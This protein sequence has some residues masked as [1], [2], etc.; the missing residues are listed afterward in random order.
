MNNDTPQ[1]RQGSLT[2]TL[3]LILIVIALTVAGV[4][5]I[6]NNKPEAKRHELAAYKVKVETIKLHL[7]QHR[8]RIDGTGEIKA[9]RSL[10]IK[11]EVSGLIIEEHPALEVGA[12]INEGDV[13]YKIDP[14]DT[15][16]TAQKIKAELETAKLRLKEEMGRQSLA[17]Q[18]WQNLQLEHANVLE[19]ELSL[20]EPHLAKAKADVEAAEASYA[21]AQLNIERCTIKAPFKCSIMNIYAH[22]GSKVSPQDRCCQLLD[23]SRLDF[24]LQ[25]RQEQLRWIHLDSPPKVI[26]ELDQ[27]QTL[28]GTIKHI[29]PELSQP[30]RMATVIVELPSPEALLQKEILVSRFLKAHFESEPIPNS[31]IIPRHAIHADQTVWI[32]SPTDTLVFQNIQWLPYGSDQALVLNGISDQQ[33]LIVSDLSTPVEGMNC[34]R[35]TSDSAH[36]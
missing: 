4:T 15:S 33:W 30:G 27:L 7:G 25:L 26:L 16:Y 28:E 35:R 12:I 22:K 2:I 11:P 5:L 13:L 36:E 32:L 1:E 20:R 21:M 19:K 29:L 9:F 6:N 34:E 23:I 10:E 8:L 3:F 18:E 14:R 24:H 17:Q 31:V